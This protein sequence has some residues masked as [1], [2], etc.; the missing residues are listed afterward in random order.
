M[1]G[2][3]TTPDTL[4]SQITFKGTPVIWQHR[5]WGLGDANEEHNN[6]IFFHGEKG[7]I[8]ATDSSVLICE[9]G[10]N[11]KKEELSLPGESVQ[12]LHMKNFLDSVRTKDKKLISCPPEDAFRSTSTVQLAMISYY[13]GSVVNW[14]NEK[15]E[16]IANPAAS[17]MLKREYRAKYIH[18]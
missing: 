5:L 15:K 14:D 7:L 13:T 10:K 2:R 16:I 9:S 18:P 11:G 3:I 8:F 6:G 17:K 12:E 4:T 1:K